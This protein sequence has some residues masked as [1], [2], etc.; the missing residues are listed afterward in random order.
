[1]SDFNILLLEGRNHSEGAGQ[2]SLTELAVAY[3]TELW[4]TKDAITN[5]SAGAAPIVKF[6]HLSST[7][8][9]KFWVNAFPKMTLLTKQL[10][11]PKR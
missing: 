8:V 4:L 3:R 2:P 6:N 1:L 5:C 9:P 7:P 11:A 10:N